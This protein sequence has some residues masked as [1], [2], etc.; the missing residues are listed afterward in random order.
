VEFRKTRQ[1]SQFGISFAQFGISFANSAQNERWPLCG[2][3]GPH[4]QVSGCRP[5]V[6]VGRPSSMTVQLAWV[7]HGKIKT[8]L[9]QFDDGTCYNADGDKIEMQFGDVMLYGE[10][11]RM[12][13]EASGANGIYQQQWLL[14]IACVGVHERYAQ[15]REEI[16][17]MTTAVELLSNLAFGRF[18]P[19]VS[20]TADKTAEEKEIYRQKIATA[21]AGTAQSMQ[22][23]HAPPLLTLTLTL[24]APR[25]RYRCG[26][27]IK[28]VRYSR[29]R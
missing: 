2:Q 23:R 9:V 27:G 6:Q 1:V 14:F 11:L 13:V 8:F 21:H 18:R 29:T 17:A 15:I 4:T 26:R 28:L 20:R 5:V 25:P 22:V 3:T 7:R 24:R 16:N 12:R 10:D 19:K